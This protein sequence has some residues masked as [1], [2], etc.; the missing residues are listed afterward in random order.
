[1]SN[2]NVF[3]RHKYFNEFQTWNSLSPH[4]KSCVQ[5]S[6]IKY[7]Q[8]LF[9]MGHL[10]QL[11]WNLV[12]PR[13]KKQQ[14]LLLIT[15]QSQKGLLGLKFRVCLSR[16][17]PVIS[18]TNIQFLFLNKSGTCHAR[19][20]ICIF[21]GEEKVSLIYRS[22]QQETCALCRYTCRLIDGEQCIIM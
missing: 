21:Q 10:M 14:L 7:L 4:K 9:F 18:S 20:T 1:M 16:Q 6:L 19:G 3:Q 5:I 2:R 13:E 17:F 11:L 8:K 15:P 22:S 12:K